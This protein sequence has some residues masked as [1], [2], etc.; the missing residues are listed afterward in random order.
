MFLTPKFVNPEILTP[1]WNVFDPKIFAPFFQPKLTKFN[2][3]K[4]KDL[5]KMAKNLTWAIFVTIERISPYLSD[6]LK[7]ST[8]L[9]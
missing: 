2:P 9:V 8:K 1:K 7:S 5:T 3:K 4:A 6:S